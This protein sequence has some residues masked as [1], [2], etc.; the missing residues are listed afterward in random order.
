MA[1]CAAKAVSEPLKYK[2]TKA[3]IQIFDAASASAASA[4]PLGVS[5]AP[6]V[7][8]CPDWKPHALMNW[9]FG[10]DPTMRFPE[11]TFF[12]RSWIWGARE[13]SRHEVKKWMLDRRPWSADFVNLVRVALGF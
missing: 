8:Q 9:D 11:H 6:I 7:Y 10:R 2:I 1:W 5:T 4:G 3:D 12:E 13:M